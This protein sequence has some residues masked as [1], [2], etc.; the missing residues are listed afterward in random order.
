MLTAIGIGLVVA[1]LVVALYGDVKVSEGG[2]FVS[3]LI[4]WPAG[5]AKWLKIAIGLAFIYAGVMML[6]R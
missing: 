4:R 1:G 6:M 3:R 5:R 2:G